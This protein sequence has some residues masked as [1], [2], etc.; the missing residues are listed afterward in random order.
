MILYQTVEDR[1]NPDQ[2]ESM[3][4]VRCNAKN[5]WLGHGYYFWDTFIENAHWWGKL[6]YRSNYVIV[7]YS[8]T[9]LADS[10]CFDLHGNMEHLQAFKLILEEMR[11]RN[12]VNEKTTVAHIIEFLK[13]TTKFTDTYDSIRACGNYSKIPDSTLP[14]EP[15]LPALLDVN[16]PVQICLFSKLSMGLSRGAIVY[17]PRYDMEYLA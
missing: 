15:R 10:R 4:P 5:A 7:K 2:I 8:A 13:R 1:E 11:G 6:R 12:L 16:P 17:P 9:D 3:G 14:F